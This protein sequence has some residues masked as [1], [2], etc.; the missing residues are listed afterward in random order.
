MSTAGEQP[1]ESSPVLISV[2]RFAVSFLKLGTFGFGGPIALA[3]CRQRDLV[4]DRR[5]AATEDYIEGL[6][7]SQL[8]PGVREVA[9]AKAVSDNPGARAVSVYPGLEDGQPVAKVT[10]AIGN[11]WNTVSESLR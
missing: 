1:P 5:W 9:V 6:A 3:G 4:E 2:L 11:E 8:C 10:L 7:F